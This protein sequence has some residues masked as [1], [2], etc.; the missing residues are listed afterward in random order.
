MTISL[1]LDKASG[2]TWKVTDRG[3][4][5]E[6]RGTAAFEDETLALTPPDQPPMVG[7]IL[8]KDDTHFQFRAVGAPAADPGLTF[9]P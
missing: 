8:W 1:S 9:G 5:R 3:Q 7:K 2:F 4:V 6:F